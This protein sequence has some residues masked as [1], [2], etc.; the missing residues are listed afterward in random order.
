VR[1]VLIFAVAVLGSCSDSYSAAELSGKYVLSIGGG[2]STIQLNLDR[3][4]M[5]SF[6]DK[7]GQVEHQE[8]SWDLEALQA[9]STVALRNFVP[10]FGEGTRG[11]G[12]YLLPVKRLFGRIFLITDIDLRDGY[13]RD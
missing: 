2:V 6:K 3:T 11:E 9:G 4:Y 12:T 7:D 5:H 1:L 13:R 10:L 8:G